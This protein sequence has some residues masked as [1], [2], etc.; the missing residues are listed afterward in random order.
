MTYIVEYERRARAD[1]RRLDPQIARRVREAIEDLAGR[2]GS[3][4]HRRLAGPL[5]D[6]YSLRVGDYRVRYTLDHGN[7]RITVLRAGHRSAAY[8][9]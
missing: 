7:R 4:Q 1:L 8:E 3:Y 6:Q 9:R 2:A 5:N